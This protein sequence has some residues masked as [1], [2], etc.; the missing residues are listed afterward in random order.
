MDKKL[1]MKNISQFLGVFR[2]CNWLFMGVGV[3][4]FFWNK[5]GYIYIDGNNNVVNKRC[6]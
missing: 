6:R 1:D 4:F 2:V 3:I 5:Y